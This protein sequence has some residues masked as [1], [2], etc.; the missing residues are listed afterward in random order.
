MIATIRRIACAGFAALLLS[1]PMS[2]AQTP[3]DIH[4]YF[5]KARRL[6]REAQPGEIVVAVIK[7]E[8]E[9]AQSPPAKAGDIAAPIGA[10]NP[11]ARSSSF[12]LRNRQP[13]RG[14]DGA[15]ERGRLAPL[16]AARRGYA[17]G[18]GD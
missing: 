13:I 16:S 8:G 4:A 3:I 10:L 6:S 18:R 1:G 2:F 15:R 5:Q 17:L 7:G 9:E 12:R 11:A 14:A